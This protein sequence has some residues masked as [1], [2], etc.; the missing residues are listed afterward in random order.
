MTNKCNL[1][2]YSTCITYTVL[3]KY[4]Q[5]R[6]EGLRSSRISKLK[7]SRMLSA[8]WCNS[9]NISILAAYLTF[10]S[11]NPGIDW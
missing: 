11:S 2:A 7:P 3:I 9:E 6:G 8:Q 10:V 1:Q 5:L 4:K